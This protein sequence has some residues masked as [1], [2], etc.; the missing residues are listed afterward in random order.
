MVTRIKLM[1]SGVEVKQ[2]SLRLRTTAVRSGKKD[3]QPF[4]WLGPWRVYFFSASLIGPYSRNFQSGIFFDFFFLSI[5]PKR[6]FFVTLGTQNGCF[7]GRRFSRLGGLQVLYSLGNMKSWRD[8]NR[9]EIQFAGESHESGTQ[10]DHR[11]KMS[12]TQAFLITDFGAFTPPETKLNV[13]LGQAFV[14]CRM[15]VEM[16]KLIEHIVVVGPARR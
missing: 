5:C 6:F 11:D 7:F 9:G 15:L 1:A 4:I 13:G 2:D 10:K 14:L 12:F 16:H 8:Q 3:H